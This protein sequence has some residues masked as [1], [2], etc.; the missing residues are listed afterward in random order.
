MF[1]SNYPYYVVAQMGRIISDNYI[2]VALYAGTVFYIFFFF[3]KYIIF[4]CT[5][6]F[7]FISK[8]QI[9]ILFNKDEDLSAGN[10]ILIFTLNNVK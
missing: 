2:E 9:S 10:Q 5:N 3:Q 8:N 6:M 1:C 4:I 7:L